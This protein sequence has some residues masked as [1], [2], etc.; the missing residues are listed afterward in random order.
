MPFEINPAPF[1]TDRIEA[2]D[3]QT[4][5][6]AYDTAE[7]ERPAFWSETVPAAFR[8]ENPIASFLQSTAPV[9]HL[10]EWDASYDVFDDLAGY[11]DFADRLATARNKRHADQIKTDI[12]AEMQ[13]QEVLS[14][15]GGLGIVAGIAAGTLSP[16]ILMPGG[17]VVR[18]TKGGYSLLR[19]AGNTA[20]WGAAGMAVSEAALQSS[21]QTR[22]VEES[23]INIGAGTL[24]AGVIGAGAAKYLG[25]AGLSELSKRV[26]QD[27]FV[28][29]K[30]DL[31][32]DMSSEVAAALRQDVRNDILSQLE[33]TGRF[34]SEV[35]R[36]YADILSRIYATQAERQGMTPAELY[37]QH[38]VRIEGDEVSSAVFNQGPVRLDSPEFQ[39]WFGGSKVVDDTGAPM[40]MYHG[41]SRSG[42]DTFDTDGAGYGLMGKGAYFTDNPNIASEYTD[43]GA[44]MME[45]RGETPKKGV[46][47]VYL[48][49]KNP[50]DMDAP[51]DLKA[52]KEALP[53]YVAEGHFRETLGERPTNEAVLREIEEI[54]ADEYIPDYEGA[55]IIQ[56]GLRRMGYDGITHIGGGRVYTDGT[57][58]RVYIALDAEQIKSVHNRGTFDANNPNILFQSIEDIRLKYKR[59]LNALM[60]GKTL[61]INQIMQLGLTPRPLQAVGMRGHPLRIPPSVVRKAIKDKHAVPRDVIERLP[62]L[63]ADPVAVMKS[64]S[65]GY[66]VLLDANDANGLPVIVSV[67]V[68]QA[69]RANVIA[70]VYGRAKPVEWFNE[71]FTKGRLLYARNEGSLARFKQSEKQYLGGKPRSTG[72]GEQSIDTRI[73]TKDDLVKA[74]RF[75]Q[76]ARGAFN[77]DNWAISL[78]KSADKSTFLHEV[79]HFYLELM[80]RMAREAGASPAIKADL[81]ATLKWLGVKNADEWNARSLSE[82]RDAHEKFAKGFEAY[83][84][85]GKAPNPEV[86]GVFE[87]FREWL[88]EIY[89]S[90]QNLGVELNDDIRGIYDRMIGTTGR[91][92]ES[93]LG[94]MQAPQETLTQNTLKSAFG[95]EK[96]SAD[97][98]INPTVRMMSSPSLKARQVWEQMVEGGAFLNKHAEGRT[99][100][101]AV[102]SLLQ[103]YYAPF[104]KAA[105][106][107]DAQYKAYRQRMRG[108]PSRLSKTEFSEQ[109]SYALR[110]GDSHFLP[111]VA[112]AARAYRAVSDFVAEEGVRLGFWDDAVDVA[113]KANGEDEDPF[114]IF[115][116]RSGGKSNAKPGPAAKFAQSYLMRSWNREKI[117]RQENLFRQ[118]IGDHVREEADKIM[119]YAEQDYN[120]KVNNLRAEAAD[121]EMRNLRMETAK[122][123]ELTALDIQTLVQAAREGGAP[124]KPQTLSAFVKSIGGLKDDDGMAARYGIGNRHM[125]GIVS[126][127]GKSADEAAAA[128]FK[129]GFFPGRKF[130]P[131]ANELLDAIRDEIGGVRMTVREADA[132]ALRAFEEY[133]DVLSAL[134]SVGIDTADMPKGRTAPK[135]IAPETLSGI[136][137]KI[138]AA[139]KS[140]RESRIAKIK[141]KIAEIE[142]QK[143]L[144]MDS[145]FDLTNEMEGYVGG[146]VDDLFNR[147]TGRHGT[148]LPDD[149]VLTEMGP[150]KGKTLRIPDTAVEMFLDNDIRDVT[151]RYVRTMSAQFEL[152]RK[153]GDISL[154]NQIDEI[155]EEYAQRR[156]ENPEQA[157]RLTRLEKEDIQYIESARDL[158]LGVPIDNTGD[159]TARVLSLFRLWNYV[160][161]LGQVTVS[162]LPDAPKVVMIHGMSRLFG[163]LIVPMAKGLK[164]LKMQ[165]R[166]AKMMGAITERVLGTRALTL[167]ELNDPF[168]RGSAFERFLHNSVGPTFSKLTLANAWNDLWKTV[169]NMVTQTRVLENVEAL[170]K[171]GKLDKKE[172]EYLAFLGIDTDTAKRI[173]QQ[174]AEHGE[175]VDGLPVAHTDRWTDR[176]AVRTFRAA[177][178]KETR[179]VVVDGS[180]VGDKPLMMQKQWGKTVFQFRSFFFASNQRTLM[181]GL[182]QRDAAALS[183]VLLSITAGMA[184]AWFKAAGRGED[185]SDWDA[186]KWIA[187]GIDQS[188]IL[189][190][191]VEVNN[192]W[193]KAGLPGFYRLMG[194]TPASRYANRNLVGSLMG[195]TFGIAQDLA[196]MIRLLGNPDDLKESDI[197]A[198][199]RLIPFQNIFYLRWLF[200]QMEGKAAEALGAT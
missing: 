68:D 25:R 100:G 130:K 175:V 174:Y 164:G 22:T 52:W 167:A 77:P 64:S 128:A 36:D 154:K 158:L 172:R 51:A 89:K 66:I 190:V 39:N 166:E 20:K 94:A 41:T 141:D 113:M 80:N 53:D 48:S 188:G 170:A 26:E 33:N 24:L 27:L 79:G 145:R 3:P 183:G 106:T 144:E 196:G 129:A 65:D 46:Y 63:M 14:S 199:R 17:A 134:R 139:T 87:R 12:D 21:Q 132:D 140:R 131:D 122:G 136:R 73:L 163:D 189:A 110:R 9:R 152:R 127:K 197:R 120:R 179:N 19:T 91:A 101:P 96:L 112:E 168:A 184:V 62:D 32:D 99:A 31:V 67:H 37:A 180:G 182:Q 83:L 108:Q 114:G 105:E 187:E 133:E 11:E 115:A 186:N 43:K 7:P 78:F 124:K 193:E 28:P 97:L 76:D 176:E 6:P 126:R 75:T 104:V 69:H 151:R 34:E 137:E 157:D 95:W 74:G 156:M 84:M 44:S 98:R 171:A 55:D 198:I 90:V 54:I 50:I 177:L 169:G 153:F 71:Q 125:V 92:R 119:R 1:R 45:H 191:L 58:H 35:N 143:H 70:S 81:E 103:E 173:A 118:V 93:N 72:A 111:E 155:R 150:L 121:L 23:V 181:R 116:A 161:K 15:S 29:E 192:T 86:V 162:S 135:D 88:V 57:R 165:A 49:I 59:D 149:F 185:T 142:A 10:D 147:M 117:Q 138:N 123:G 40:V 61:P 47:P 194:E 200:D 146:I 102:E 30:T 195:P 159:L 60:S 178:N 85:E 82:K 2:F 107:E 160:T 5:R 18:G 16:E 8:R 56:D 109:I 13:A 38:P 4:D 42:F 148:D